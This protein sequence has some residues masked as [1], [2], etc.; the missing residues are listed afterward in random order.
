MLKLSEAIRFGRMYLDKPE[1]GNSATCAI[2]MALWGN[3]VVPIGRSNV[4]EYDTD[5]Q[6]LRSLYPWLEKSRVSCRW[7]PAGRILIGTQI[8]FH[9]FDYHVYRHIDGVTTL[10]G[11]CDWIATF[12][13]KTPDKPITIAES[14]V[15]ASCLTTA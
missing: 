1:G 2:G 3:G 5:Y 4:W 11:L 12:E 13:P 15:G 7:C 6:T 9:V 8:V 10:D 14:T